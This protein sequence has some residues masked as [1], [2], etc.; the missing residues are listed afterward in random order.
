MNRLLA[1]LALL[2]ASCAGDPPAAPASDA[3]TV[4]E[5][6]GLAASGPQ[7]NLRPRLETVSRTIQDPGLRA[8]TS[9]SLD[10]IVAAAALHRRVSDLGKDVT[11]LGGLVVVEGGG[12]AW[13]RS[14][15]GDPAMQVFDRLVT[16]SLNDK[17]NPHF[18]D[19]KLN[20]RVNDAWME[21][22]S[23]LPDLRALDVANMDVRGPGLRAAGTLRSL[24]SI[25]LTLTPITD[26]SLGA[27]AGL[28]RLKVLGLA[29]T[30]VTGTGMEPLQGLR[31]LENLNFHSTP[32]NDAG[33]EWI[34]KMSCLL[35]LEIV[36][37]QFTDA[38][39]RALSGLLNLE[40]LQLG[41]RKA[42]G[43]GLAFLH[44]L[45]RLREL[46]VHDGMLTPEGFRNVGA[47]RT[48]RVLRAYGGS[49]GDES[50]RA[51]ADLSELETLIL[52]GIGVTDAGLETLSKF[53]KLRKLTLHEPKVS[54]AAT[55]RLRAALPALEIAR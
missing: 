14:L 42:T 35:R 3:A 34:G 27:L 10:E 2:L 30:K 50:L 48:L 40:R 8:K 38:G 6:L 19:Y 47:A 13:M 46:D 31:K 16:L 37:T 5:L 25:N 7:E 41:S 33:L 45:P 43:A 21:R 39:T 52:E 36:H 26:E 9:G 24:E 1:G 53:T 18:K 12:P 11:E 28:T 29:S 22:L 32:V 20:T 55:G 51:L 17:T 54:E 23:G 49:G 4:K 44:D 15:A